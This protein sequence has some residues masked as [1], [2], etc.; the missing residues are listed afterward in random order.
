M[1]VIVNPKQEQVINSLSTAIIQAA[2]LVP[3]MDLLSC[4][5]MSIDK[6]IRESDDQHKGSPVL[7]CV[8]PTILNGS[9]FNRGKN[10][11][12]MTVKERVEILNRMQEYLTA[13]GLS[14]AKM[15]ERIEEIEPSAI[16][17]VASGAVN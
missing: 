11:E 3:P 15:I 7:L 12:S 14:I 6:L 16:S 13:V 17:S 4:I 1:K 2:H 5:V 9:Y 8:G 10:D